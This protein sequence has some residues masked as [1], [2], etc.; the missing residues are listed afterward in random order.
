MP[1]RIAFSKD[2][3]V[4]RRLQ[5]QKISESEFDKAEDVVRWMGAIQAQDFAAAKWAVGQR[6][7]AVTDAAIEQAFA[8]GKILRTHVMRPTWHF[9]APEDIRWLLKLTAPRVNAASAYQYRRLELDS[10]IFKRSSAIIEKALLGGK[11]LTR[12]ELGSVLERSGIPIID[13]RLT[14]IVM[15]AESDG[16]ICSGAR[17][18]KQFTYALLDERAP[19]TKSLR[20]DEALA[21]LTARY[22]RSHGPATLQDFVWW[23]GLTTADAKSGLEIVKQ[24]FM[25]E[26]VDDQ[27]YWFSDSTSSKKEISPSVYLLPNYDEYIVGYT[28]R[29]A[30]FDV[31]HIQ[32]LDARSNPLFM[33]TIV[34]N[35]QIAGTW[36]RTL[37]AKTVEVEIEVNPFKPLTKTEKKNLTDA[38]ELFGKFLGLR[39]A[40]ADK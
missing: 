5:N 39:V 8:D 6:T 16:V 13:L 30:I 7:K 2:E 37:K 28:D 32:K 23:S 18:G 35:G 11:Q 34:I 27:I 24:Q 4:R 9:V 10:A 12:D 15:R 36:K 31:S 21:E 29:G 26:S 25:H 40:R 22:F 14:Y 38:A 19:Q 33:H 3:V 17:R 20:R 1:N